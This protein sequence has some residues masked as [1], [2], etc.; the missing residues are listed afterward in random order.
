MGE[1]IFEHYAHGKLLL[2]G[3]YFVLDGAKALAIPTQFGQ[4]FKVY[5]HY[6]NT[7]DGHSER[8]EESPG[9]FSQ[10]NDWLLWKSFDHENKVWFEATFILEEE[11]SIL[12]VS[13]KKIGDNLLQ[14]LNAALTISGLSF[15]SGL[16]IHTYLEFPNNWGLGSSS[17]LVASLAEWFEIDPFEL[18]EESFGGSGYDLAC[19]TSDD[20]IFFQRNIPDI[21]VT[22]V[23]L[24]WPFKDQICFVH[25][26]K[27]QNSREGIAHYNSLP[28][29]NKKAV[30]AAITKISEAMVGVESIDQF[31]TLIEQHENLVSENL[32]LP[33]VK[34][35]YFHD[36]NGSVKSLGA[37]GGDFVMAVSKEVNYMEDYF[38]AKGYSTVIPFDEMMYKGI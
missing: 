12:T 23:S 37:W 33:K 35:L 22:L 15:E 8:S 7:S 19:A 27:K 30:V 13:D 24:K 29:E 21:D 14:L 28:L 16:E 18:L 3:E 34:D 2:S 25:L 38:K 20:P 6:D 1:V 17:T 10:Q 26:G 11:I 32:Q 9:N 5:H 36:F 4:H 31:I